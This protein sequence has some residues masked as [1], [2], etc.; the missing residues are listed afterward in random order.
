[1]LLVRIIQW[2]QMLK[3]EMQF[4]VRMRPETLEIRNPF[5][6]LSIHQSSTT[7]YRLNHITQEENVLKLCRRQRR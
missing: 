5:K 7:C 1:M 2:K 6:Y 3:C 4:K